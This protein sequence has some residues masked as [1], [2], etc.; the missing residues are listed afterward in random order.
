MLPGF[1]VIFSIRI[2]DRMISFFA[3][4]PRASWVHHP[5]S[6]VSEPASKIQTVTY[7]SDGLSFSGMPN[8][9]VWPQ[10]SLWQPIPARSHRYNLL[11]T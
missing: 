5:F 9:E 8:R 6:L 11:L 1:I 10:G 4:F 2:T 3:S 7:M